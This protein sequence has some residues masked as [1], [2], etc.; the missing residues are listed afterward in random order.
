MK[1]NRWRIPEPVGGLP[2]PMDQVDLI[3]V[4]ALACDTLGHRLGQGLGYYDEFLADTPGIRLCVCLDLFLVDEIAHEPHDERVDIIVTESR[5][6]RT[7]DRNA[8]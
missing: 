3:L 2:A 1:P 6:I 5:I 8:P 4:P 7:P